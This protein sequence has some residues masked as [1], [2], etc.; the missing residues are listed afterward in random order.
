M[1]AELTVEYPHH[2]LWQSIAVFRCD[3]EK[4]P[5]RYA[6][7]R[8]VY[9]LAKRSDPSGLLKTLIPQYEYIAAA[10]IRF[11][12]ILSNKR[13]LVNFWHFNE[14]VQKFAQYELRW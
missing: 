13:I 11:I 4:Q 5:L 3:S 1:L 8:A 10:F 2:C 7:C 6:R 14:S 12:F 9:E